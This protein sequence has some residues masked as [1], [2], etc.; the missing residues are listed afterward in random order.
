MT[1][2]STAQLRPKK[3]VIAHPS[4]A[5]IQQSILRNGLSAWLLEVLIVFLVF[6]LVDKRSVL[7]T[8]YMLQTVI[9]DL[10]PA[11]ARLHD[12]STADTIARKR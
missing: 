2:R 11:T 9:I 1:P 6:M 5:D 4:R 8:G 10:F 3:V 7:F 12:V